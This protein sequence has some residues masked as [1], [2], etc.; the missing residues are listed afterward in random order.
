MNH[1]KPQKKNYL[2]K[3]LFLQGVFKR[4]KMRPDIF[5]DEKSSDNPILY[6][7]YDKMP[8]IFTGLESWPMSTN[9]KCG[10]CH[11]V[12]KSRPWFEPQSIDF[13]SKGKPG[14]MV[15]SKNLNKG[16]PENKIPNIIPKGVFC[17]V[18]CV[19]THIN[20]FSK[21]LAEKHDKT[22]MLKIVYEIFTGKTIKHI[23]PVP[24]ITETEP[25]GG[26]MSM[27][28]YQKRIDN[29]TNSDLLDTASFI[30]NC[31]VVF[32]SS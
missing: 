7:I 6:K 26:Y 15:D 2:E 28:E 29:A 9:L 23:E 11:R 14:I 20:V 32:T 31:K 13:V 16:V 3:V 22:A 1:L 27:Q 5:G 25:Y 4:D 24:L 8:L 18:G 30:E 10:T 19:Q 21:N 17:S 12:P